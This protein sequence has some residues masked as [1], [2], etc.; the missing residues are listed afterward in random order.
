MR[1]A[2]LWLLA[3]A[4]CATPQVQPPQEVCLKIL[5][6]GLDGRIRMYDEVVSRLDEPVT[7]AVR[8]EDPILSVRYA[9]T[10]H[11]EPDGR[12]LVSL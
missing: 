11:R 5:Y 12:H 1:K 8:Q 3:P 2:L 6:L 4:A 7:D 9:Y 10:V